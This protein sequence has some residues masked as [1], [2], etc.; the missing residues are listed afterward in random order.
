MDT[1]AEFEVMISQTRFTISQV[2]VSSEPGY[3]VV[4]RSQLVGSALCK[5]EGESHGVESEHD[6]HSA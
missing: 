4:V 6:G 3:A 5:I 1:R 2:V